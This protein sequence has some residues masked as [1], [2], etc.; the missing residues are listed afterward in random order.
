MDHHTGGLVF[1]SPFA[2]CV[3]QS[4]GSAPGD[5]FP[6]QVA[7]RLIDLYGV[8]RHEVAFDGRHSH[9]QQTPVAVQEGLRRSSINGQPTAGRNRSTRQV[10]KRATCRSVMG[11][12]EL[13]SAAVTMNELS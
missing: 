7:A 3:P 12:I 9:G 6:D 13:P 11:V 2:L 5:P 4:G 8:T 10:T 1:I